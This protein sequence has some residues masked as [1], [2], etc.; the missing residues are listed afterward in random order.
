VEVTAGTDVDTVERL[1]MV[2]VDPEQG[3]MV[4]NGAA[5]LAWTWVVSATVLHNDEEL[6]ADL[7][8]HVYELMHKFHDD[9]AHIPGVGSLIR[10]ED[11]SM[12]SHTATTATPAGGLTQFNGTWTVTV[13]KA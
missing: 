10:T 7:A 8:D 6:C 3:T 4:S 12:P 1:P 9:G 11:I 2:I 5:G 13:Q